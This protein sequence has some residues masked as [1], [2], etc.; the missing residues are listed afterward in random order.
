LQR[1]LAVLCALVD[2]LGSEPVA[3]FWEAE[4]VRWLPPQPGPKLFALGLPPGLL[5]GLGVCYLTI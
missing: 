5:E 2:H 1:D 3:H 4:Q